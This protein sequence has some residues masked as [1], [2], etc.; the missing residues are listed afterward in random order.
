MLY[1]VFD[2]IGCLWWKA[3]QWVIKVW[4]AEGLNNDG[5]FV[6]Y[7]GLTAAKRHGFPLPLSE[8]D[9]VL[10]REIEA[11]AGTA[12]F[13]SAKPS[14]QALRGRTS[15]AEV[16][17]LTKSMERDSERFTNAT[18]NQ[19]QSVISEMMLNPHPVIKEMIHGTTD[20]GY[21]YAEA[22]YET[23][24]VIEIKNKQGTVV[25]SHSSLF[26][27]PYARYD[28]H[29]AGDVWDMVMDPYLTHEKTPPGS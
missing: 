11:A 22:V 12:Q 13:E 16:R 27:A 7:M 9:R 19:A 1:T 21:F 24:P 5:F 23:E 3:C 29:I 10:L 6:Q 8:Y 28:R 4:N 17:I 2:L 14:R 15:T 20:D 26:G 25:E 18:E